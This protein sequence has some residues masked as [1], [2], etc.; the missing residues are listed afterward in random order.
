MA[1][2]RRPTASA[3]DSDDDSGTV[4]AAAARQAHWRPVSAWIQERAL[5]TVEH[6][7][8]ENREAAEVSGRVRAQRR[9]DSMFHSPGD[10]RNGEVMR[11]HQT[12]REDRFTSLREVSVTSGQP[13]PTKNLTAQEIVNQ[14][15][16]SQQRAQE[17][18]RE[19][20]ADL[21]A[22]LNTMQL[23]QRPREAGAYSAVSEQTHKEQV[24]AY[25]AALLPVA[26]TVSCTSGAQLQAWQRGRRRACGAL[27]V[28]GRSHT[29]RGILWNA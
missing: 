21:K 6:R 4:H 12:E 14:L 11:L 2:P 9:G 26:V 18:G 1:T 16:S 3:S 27:A 13:P 25:A 10:G 17:L 29:G 7:V 22:M 23:E 15:M 20:T 28:S 19:S 8:K 5:K 24:M